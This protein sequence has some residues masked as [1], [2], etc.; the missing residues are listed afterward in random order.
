MIMIY[1][2]DDDEEDV[3]VTFSTYHTKKVILIGKLGRHCYI[4][5]LLNILIPL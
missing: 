2:G 1:T 5:L 4:Q 3:L